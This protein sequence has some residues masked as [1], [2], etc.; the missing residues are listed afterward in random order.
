MK[1]API[2]LC[3]VA[4]LS[5]ADLAERGRAVAAAADRSDLGF[6][7]SRVTVRMEIA[8]RRGRTRAR[9]LELRT[10]ERESDQVGDKT[11]IIFRAP[12]DIS[13][14]ALLSHAALLDDDQ[15][16]LYLPRMGR[17]K[18][19][20]GANKSGAFVGTE[21]SFEDL[22][23]QELNK[24]DYRWLRA[25]TQQQPVTDVVERIPRYKRSA[26]TKQTVWFARSHGQPLRIDFFGRNGA[27]HKRLHFEDYRAYDGIW[28]AHRMHMTNLRTGK[29]TTLHF[30]DYDFALDYTPRDFQ[31]AILDAM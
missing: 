25:E 23:A 16:W 7:T 15:Q 20:S 11:L 12:A 27:E 31:R 28:R 3:F 21:F 18:R 24:Y 9:E 2:L 4:T 1:I 5:H 19:I 14:T 29:T 13:R 10:L 6:R 26:Y 17:V 30:G 22:T 8:D